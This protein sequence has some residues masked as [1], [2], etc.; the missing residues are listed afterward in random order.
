MSHCDLGTDEIRRPPTVMVRDADE[1]HARLNSA[2]ASMSRLPIDGGEN[3]RSPPSTGSPLTDE[4]IRRT[5]RHARVAWLFAYLGLVLMAIALWYLRSANVAITTL[6]SQLA[7]K[8]EN[9]S[10][11][12]REVRR[13][14]NIDFSLPKTIASRRTR[15]VPPDW[16]ER[17]PR[18]R[19]S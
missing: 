15:R 11:L 8:Q 4:L 9:V 13:T 18:S 12:A 14:M 5:L 19:S 3:A 16:R 7:Q 6:S 17:R 1:G 2:P 10:S